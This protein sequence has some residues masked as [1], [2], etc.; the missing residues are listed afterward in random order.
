M[1]IS[2]RKISEKDINQIIFWIRQPHV[3]EFWYSAKEKSDKELYEKYTKRIEND[4]ILTLLILFDQKPI[5]LIQSYYLDD[6]SMF[7]IDHLAKGIDLF[8]GEIDQIGFGYGQKLLLQFL[9]EYIF[10]DPS[11]KYACIDPEVRNERAIHV[12]SKV[13]FQI[14]NTAIDKVSGLKTCYMVLSRDR[15]L[16]E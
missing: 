2:F 4:R 16:N 1:N 9:H 10:S 3:S 13:G 12:Y 14:V 8:V 11:V 6:T 7:N 5:G 15:F